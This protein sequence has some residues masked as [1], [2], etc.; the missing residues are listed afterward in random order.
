MQREAPGAGSRPASSSRL[1]SLIAWGQWELTEVPARRWD[2]LKSVVGGGTTRE[3]GD[4][5]S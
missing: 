4:T 1:E 3:T 5:E 2:W